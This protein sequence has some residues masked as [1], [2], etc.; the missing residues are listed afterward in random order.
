MNKITKLGKQKL[1]EQLDNLR[2][3]YKKTL[4][5]RGI[6]GREGDLK[7]N[8]AYISLGEKAQMLSIQI[9]EAATDLKKCVV[10]EAPTNTDTIGFGHKVTLLYENDKR[11]MAIV[12]VGKNDA[13]IK[14]EW[15]SIESP[16]G[17]ALSGKKKGEKIIIND[18]PITILDVAVGE[19]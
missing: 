16:I 7:E 14:P 4:V 12:L 10:Q 13:R 17:Q 1:Q 5:N 18:Q 11:E 19:I 8:A 3:E 9:E 6:A 2:E 15:I